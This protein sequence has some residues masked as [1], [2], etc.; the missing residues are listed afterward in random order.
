MK[1]ASL[2]N[3]LL[4]LVVLLDFAGCSVQKRDIQDAVAAG[5]VKVVEVYLKADPHLINKR[6]E[7]GWTLLHVAAASGKKD[8]AEF[9]IDH[10]AEVDAV[11][12]TGSTPLCR[13]TT[14]H[15]FLNTALEDPKQI[16]EG[17]RLVAE[18]LLLRGA[19]PNGRNHAAMSPVVMT[20]NC[21]NESMLELLLSH[22]ADANVKT[23]DGT[24]PLHVVAKAITIGTKDRGPFPELTEPLRIRFAELLVANG[25]D[26]NTKDAGGHTALAYA[27][28]NRWDK[29]ADFLSSHG[30]IQ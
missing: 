16:A 12:N 28:E 30:A 18:L 9:L 8:M 6:N 5:D 29:L 11:D 7:L 22:R 2:V 20:I 27:V 17:Q 23:D 14:G 19:D 25:A 13:T 24:T 26:V 3:V 21:G 1:R 15:S 4:V 10:G